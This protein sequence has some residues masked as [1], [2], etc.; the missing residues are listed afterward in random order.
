MADKNGKD[1][2]NVISLGDFKNQKEENYPDDDVVT[3]SVTI[4]FTKAAWK[5]F[6]R[7]SEEAER[8]MGIVPS[9]EELNPIVLINSGLKLYQKMSEALAEGKTFAVVRRKKRWA[10]LDRLF[11]PKYEILGT[12]M[13]AE[14]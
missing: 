14:E 2:G 5:Y 3:H 6:N 7:I 12:F 8:G 13:C 10:M 1:D 4:D 9:N 11:G